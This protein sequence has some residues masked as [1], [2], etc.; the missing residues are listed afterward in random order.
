MKACQLTAASQPLRAQVAKERLQT[1]LFCL[2][3]DLHYSEAENIQAGISAREN[4]SNHV[5]SKWCLGR[6]QKKKKRII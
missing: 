3:E 4:S 2:S 5:I 1:G 6:V